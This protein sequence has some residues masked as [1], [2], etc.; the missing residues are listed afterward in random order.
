MQVLNVAF[1]NMFFIL[2]SKEYA[3]VEK[4]N[5]NFSRQ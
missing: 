4:Y 2:S 1:L 5:F 3:I